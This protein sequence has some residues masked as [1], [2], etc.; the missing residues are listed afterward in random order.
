ME[1]VEYFF[2]IIFLNL[3]S[4][5]MIYIYVMKITSIDYL[6][7]LC[8]EELEVGFKYY[9][10]N[11]FIH[12]NNSWKY[13]LMPIKIIILKNYVLNY[14]I[15]TCLK[16]NPKNNFF[17]DIDLF[18]LDFLLVKNIQLKI[19]CKVFSIFSHFLVYKRKMIMMKLKFLLLMR[20]MF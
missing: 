20:F 10:L 12:G 9:K 18:A 3:S 17:L 14:K 11:P 1:R 4:F 13:L 7:L 16:V 6:P 15:F 5:A 2:F 19:F 8:E